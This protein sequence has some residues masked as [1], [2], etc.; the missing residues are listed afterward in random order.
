M[1]AARILIVD[2]EDSNVRLLEAILRRDGYTDLMSMTDSR[3]AV[4]RFAEFHPDLVLLDLMMPLMDGFEVMEELKTRIPPETYVPILVLTAD[5][6]RDSR[7]RALSMGA[8]DFLTKPFDQDEVTLR[9]HNLLHTR[10]LYLRVQEEQTKL[11]ER[12]QERTREL[13]ESLTLL[14]ETAEEHR[15]LIDRLIAS[16]QA[17]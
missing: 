6:A 2:D 11:E 12:V 8:N 9:I 13:R 7:N 17:S 10:A 14:E 3:L 4:P 16:Q 15:H 1:T 5:L